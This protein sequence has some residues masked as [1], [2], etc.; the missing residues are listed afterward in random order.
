MLVAYSTG[1]ISF[2]NLA[3]WAP[4]VTHLSNPSNHF[5]FFRIWL[6]VVTKVYH[7]TGEVLFHCYMVQLDVF[8]FFFAF[9]VQS[10]SQCIFSPAVELWRLSHLWQL[11]SRPEVL[12]LAWNCVMMTFLG[13]I[14]L[15][16]S[17]ISSM[18]FILIPDYAIF[19]IY[20]ATSISFLLLHPH[21]QPCLNSNHELYMAYI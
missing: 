3:L 18:N 12:A 21:P 2:Y 13:M 4:Y 17:N 14:F 8:F 19:L 7:C 20:H 5:L 1:H 11:W 15:E 6:F 16:E 9:I 10:I